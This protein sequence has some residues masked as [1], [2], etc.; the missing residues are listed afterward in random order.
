MAQHDYI[1]EFSVKLHG[2]RSLAKAL[3]ACAFLGGIYGA[4]VGSAIGAVP[5]AAG[6]IEIAA[7]T[8]AVLVGVPGARIGLLIG[9]VTQN[10]FG[11]LFVALFAAIAGALIGAFFAT[12][13]LLAFGA[14]LGAVGGW[15]LATGII[16]LRHDVVRRFFLGIGGGIIGTFSGAILWAVHLHQDAALAGAAW[17]AGAGAVAGPVLLLMVI[18]V[19]N[20]FTKTHVSRPASYIDT[21]FEPEDHEDRHSSLPER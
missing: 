8:V 4:A 18:A 16:A 20:S 13:L 10:R 9:L 14:L 11:K 12:V 3:A 7:V 17:G 5:G 15:L 19:L 21:R 6:I 2:A 1:N